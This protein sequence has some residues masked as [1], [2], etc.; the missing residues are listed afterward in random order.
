MISSPFSASANELLLNSKSHCAEYR[1]LAV[2][3]THRNDGNISASERPSEDLL[4]KKYCARSEPKSS[5][6]WRKMTV[7]VCLSPEGLTI[8]VASLGLASSGEALIV[9]ESL[10]TAS[11]VGSFVMEVS[12][13]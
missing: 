11:F 3:K 4:S 2:G 12:T 8:V 6:P 13:M 9:G 5:R 7:W 1:S 10:G